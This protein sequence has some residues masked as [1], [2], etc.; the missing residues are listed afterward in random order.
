MTV[1]AFTLGSTAPTLYLGN[2][3][4]SPNHRFQVNAADGSYTFYVGGTLNVG[5]NQHPGIY[6]GSFEIEVNYN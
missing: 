4:N 5:A 6:N 3:G 1:T 2:P